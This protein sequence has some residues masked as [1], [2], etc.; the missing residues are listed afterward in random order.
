MITT[1]I[2]TSFFI[3]KK[4]KRT[5]VSTVFFRKRIATTQHYAKITDKK[6]AQEMLRL[7]DRLMFG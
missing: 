5:D 4:T 3:K 1:P 6:V 7:N 2:K